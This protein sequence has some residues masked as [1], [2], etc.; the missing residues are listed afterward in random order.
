MG[1]VVQWH[2]RAYVDTMFG[3]HV[4]F[5]HPGNEGIGE[6]LTMRSPANLTRGL[7][8]GLQQ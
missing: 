3:G 1:H 8:E 5:A 7:G 4:A 2:T 6:M